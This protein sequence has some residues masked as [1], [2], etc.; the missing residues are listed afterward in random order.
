MKTITLIIS[1]II[2]SIGM[3]P[4]TGQIKI[5]FKDCRDNYPVYH[6]IIQLKSEN[7]KSI[8]RIITRKDNKIKKLEPGN[9]EIE[10]E[11]IFGR[12]EVEKVKVEKGK[13]IE[14]EI[15][16]N[17]FT[18]DKESIKQITIIDS[19]AVGEEY[20]I[21]Y[22]SRGCFHFHQD[23]L[24]IERKDKGFYVNCSGNLVK[25]EK[26]QIESIKDFEM[27]LFNGRMLG[28]CTT[29]DTYRLKYKNK[30][31]LINIDGSCDWR[32]F[33]YIKSKIKKETCMED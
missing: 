21:I 20:K 24:E 17:K 14:L 3:P 1:A 31:K 29:S 25:L 5:H 26:E 19:I 32:G 15:C 18:S 11:S 33:N 10:F 2:L 13:K 22:D 28:Y 27:K 23:S 6:N 9:Y 7:G 16:V 8:E 12:K 30:Y 4:K